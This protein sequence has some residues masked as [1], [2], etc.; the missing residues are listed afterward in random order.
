M[1]GKKETEGHIEK[2]ITTTIEEAVDDSKEKEEKK[3][4]LILFNI[5]ESKK[6]EIEAENDEDMLQIK[7]IMKQ[8]NSNVPLEGTF[9]MTRLGKSK[10]KSNDARPRAIKVTFQ[11]G[12]HK[13]KILSNSGKLRNTDTFSKVNLSID[14]TEKEKQSDKKLKIEL[15]DKKKLTGLDYTIFANEI[16]L[17][18]DI[19]Q[20]KKDREITREMARTRK[21]D[22]NSAPATQG[23]Q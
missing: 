18:T 23:G 13:W 9:T 7:D 15:E 1:K 11:N 10:S 22:A 5:P 3:N 4:N 8:C 12:D 6:E 14:K 19:P 17:R 20:F 16:M 2:V 21:S